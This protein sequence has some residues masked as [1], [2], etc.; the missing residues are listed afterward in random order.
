MPL[1]LSG[2]QLK[3]LTTRL[4]E[5]RETPDDL[6]ALADVRL[7]YKEVLDRAHHDVEELCGGLPHAQPLTP[8]VKTIKTTLEKLARQPH[9]KSI[10]QIRDFAGMRVVVHGTRADQDELAERIAELFADDTRSAKLIDRRAEPKSGYRAVHLEVR[11]DG[12]LI[13]IQIRTEPQHRWA[14]LFERTADKLGR[15]L[16]YDE[17]TSSLSAVATTFVQALRQAAD[18]ID[19][20]ERLDENEQKDWKTSVDHLFEQL[21]FHLDRLT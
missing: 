15:S 1:P 17:P 16:R 11:R 12:I 20:V 9:L 10:A 3:N 18:F 7:Y 8:R 2:N 13:E 14:E 5:G 4:R 6:H 19:Q 21:A